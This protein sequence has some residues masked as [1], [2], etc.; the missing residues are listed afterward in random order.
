MGTHIRTR[1][2]RSTEAYAELVGRAALGVLQA[3]S[4]ATSELQ[5]VAKR[6][7]TAAPPRTAVQALAAFTAGRPDVDAAIDYY[8]AVLALGGVSRTGIATALGGI[9]PAAVTR[10]LASQPLAHARGSD[11]IRQ[12]DGSWSVYAAG[13]PLGQLAAE[14]G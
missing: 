1:D 10:R 4:A 7:R 12:A 13:T 5:Q 3:L 11:L 2:P 6:D 8:I 14:A 9:R